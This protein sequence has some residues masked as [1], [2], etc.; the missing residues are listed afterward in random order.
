MMPRRELLHSVHGKA[1]HG[2]FVVTTTVFS[3]VATTSAMSESTKMNSRGAR[4]SKAPR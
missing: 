4:P 3:G 2:R 1:T